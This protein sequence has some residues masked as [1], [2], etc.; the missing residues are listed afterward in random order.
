MTKIANLARAKLLAALTA[1]ALCGLAL[2]PAHAYVDLGPYGLK[3]EEAM[4]VCVSQRMSSS[5]SNAV[6][7]L[8]WSPA[9]SIQGRCQVPAQIMNSTDIGNARTAFLSAISSCTGSR[10]TDDDGPWVRRVA[11]ATAII[12]AS[13]VRDSITGESL[14]DRFNAGSNTCN[15]RTLDRR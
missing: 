13:G 8:Y 15:P 5:V 14:L 1:M 9:T 7:H 4:A 2:T 12:A 10:V 11:D 6:A 3:R